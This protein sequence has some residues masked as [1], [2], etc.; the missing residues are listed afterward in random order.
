MLARL[1]MPDGRTDRVTWQYPG[2]HNAF[3]GFSLHLDLSNNGDEF[4]RID[5]ELRSRFVLVEHPFK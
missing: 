2:M 4:S 1:F 3:Y 5:R